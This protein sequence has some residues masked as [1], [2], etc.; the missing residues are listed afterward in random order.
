[1][2]KL[3][4]SDW[5]KS[6][7]QS[8]DTLLDNKNLYFEHPETAFSRTQKISL[9]DT[10]LFLMTSDHEKTAV[11]LLDY[12]QP[13]KLPSQ[14]AMSYRR[15]QLNVDAFKAVFK[16]FTSKI[17]Q[18]KTFHGKYVIAC[19]GS[20]VNTPYNPSD[21]DSFVDA[22]KGKKGFN[23]YHLV[24]CYDVLN[25][26]F[27][28][29]VIQSYHSMNE[30]LAFCEMLDRYR[31]DQ[32]LLF[33]AD[34]G[35]ASYNVIAHAI[36]HGFSFLIR[37]PLP[38]ALNIFSDTQVLDGDEF[39][40]VDTCYVGRTRD[41]SSK[42]LKNYHFLSHKKT[43]DYIPNGSKKIDQFCVRLVKIQLPEGG[44]EYLLTNLPKSEFSLKDLKELYRLRWGIETSFR[45]LKYASGMVRM[46]SLKQKFIF[47]EIFAKL[48][49]YNFCT[50]INQC[51]KVKDS[52]KSK[53]IYAVEKSYL[54]KVCIRFLKDQV[55]DIITLIEKRRVPV[56]KG[57]KFE[58]KLRRQ[59]ADT[60]QNR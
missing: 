28:D 51:T 5:K 3:S 32:N 39:D 15:N 10:M 56:R 29:A 2:N 57:R 48:T 45:Y 43:Y 7:L 55:N 6:L 12:F 36:K 30:N 21:S 54:I 27:T 4:S 58:R 8:I 11:E 17:P 38:M 24:T 26:I 20:R 14:A 19:D 52:G 50:A 31:K 46:H 42:V 37:L 23:Q 35:F 25:E 60:L 53:H 9:G 47:Q 33:V 18:K 40:I 44:Y 34:R 49:L 22:Q 1:M 13:E 59:H 16:D 41:K